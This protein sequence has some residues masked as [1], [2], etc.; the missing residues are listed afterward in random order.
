MQE[1]TH[2]EKIVTVILDQI[3]SGQTRCLAFF[4]FTYIQGQNTK[5]DQINHFQYILYTFTM[6]LNSMLYIQCIMVMAYTYFYAK[7]VLFRDYLGRSA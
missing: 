2:K 6:I 5:S 1:R 7:K 3:V 4:T